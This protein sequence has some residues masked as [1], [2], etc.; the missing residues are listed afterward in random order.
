L[1]KPVVTNR[2]AGVS[3]KKKIKKKIPPAVPGAAAEAAD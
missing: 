3:L 1:N 2:A